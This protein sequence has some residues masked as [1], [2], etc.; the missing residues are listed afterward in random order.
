MSL[1]GDV[2]AVTAV[3]GTAALADNQDLIYIERGLTGPRNARWCLR[4]ARV[5]AASIARRM[6]GGHPRPAPLSARGESVLSDG[7]TASGRIS[8]R[9]P[10]AWAGIGAV[11]LGVLLHLPMYLQAADEH[12]RLAGRASTRRCSSA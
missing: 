4:D 11:T 9:E 12:Y 5:P 8:R 7:A 2:I 3:V 1:K 10:V 6:D